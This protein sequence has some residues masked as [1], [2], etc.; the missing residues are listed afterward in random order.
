[1]VLTLLRALPGVHDL[2]V[3]V[4]CRSSSCKLGTSPGVPGPHDFAVRQSRRSSSERISVH[5]IPS[6]VRDDAYAPRSGRDKRLSSMGSGKKKQDSL[7]PKLNGV[8][9]VEIVKEIYLA[10]GP[11]Y[12]GVYHRAALRADP[13]AHPGYACSTN[14]SWPGLSRPSRLCRHRRARLV[15][16][17]G[18]RRG[19]YHR[20]ALRADPL[21][22]AR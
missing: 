15:E 12:R 3:T 1:M 13:L 9:H 11:G 6:H 22:P 18:S 17:T 5:R 4:A 2:L 8:L 16:I 20:A 21:A 14:S 19:V 10:G 7:N